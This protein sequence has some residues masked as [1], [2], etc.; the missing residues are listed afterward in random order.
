MR[1][2][3]L[4]ARRVSA[5]GLGHWTRL[6]KR[7]RMQRAKRRRRDAPASLDITIENW[8]CR[9]GNA[10][11]S[12]GLRDGRTTVTSYVLQNPT[13]RVTVYVTFYESEPEF[14]PGYDR[15]TSDGHHHIWMFLHASQ[16]GPLRASLEL[17]QQYRLA[18]LVHFNSVGDIDYAELY[19]DN[20]DTISASKRRRSR[21]A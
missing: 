8:H 9:I 11:V 21:R 19:H 17:S 12:Y 10:A 1:A 18:V 15:F 4:S 7:L 20:V 14:P 3:S 2:S 6:E 13:K 16:H 5:R